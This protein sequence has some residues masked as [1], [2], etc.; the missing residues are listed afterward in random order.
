MV[1]QMCSDALQESKL[2]LIST[3][4]GVED[5]AKCFPLTSRDPIKKTLS[6]LGSKL[7]VRF[8]PKV[9]ALLDINDAERKR[10]GRVIQHFD[11]KERKTQSSRNEAFCEQQL[12]RLGIKTSDDPQPFEAHSLDSPR[13]RPSDEV[14]SLS[15]ILLFPSTET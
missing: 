2:Q 3:F 1:F 8:N 13:P 11:D 7:M 12:Q 5:R 9:R 4:E 15:L 6:Q 14:P 10:L